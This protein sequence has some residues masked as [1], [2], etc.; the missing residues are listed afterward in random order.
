LWIP[1]VVDTASVRIAI[2][3][4]HHIFSEGLKRLLMSDGSFTIVG[5]AANGYDAITLVER[6]RP[7]VL[8]LDVAMPALGGVEALE[9]I[10]TNQVC[11]LLL[12]AGIESTDLLRA[13]QLGARGVVLKEAAPE[14]LLQ[15]IREVLR[16]KYIL[17]TGTAADLAEAVR[18]V[19]SEPAHR[20]GL[21]TRE[22]EIT[23]FI[24]D[25]R[26]NRDI[27]TA[28]DITLA[29]VK[30]HLANIFDKTGVSS[31]LELAMFAIRQ[32]LLNK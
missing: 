16:G 9:S 21:T 17:G 25:G 31:R 14:Q 22:L 8:L 11:V 32:G 26:S 3:D 2:A 23:A 13:I 30:N 18:R 27:A 12:T 29:T 15:A 10:D 24:V 7:D 6:T 20:C 5:Q 1:L 28:L 19:R 4:D